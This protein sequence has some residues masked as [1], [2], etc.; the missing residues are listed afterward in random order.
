MIMKDVVGYEGLYMVREDGEIWSVKRKKFLAQRYDKS[1]YKR[2]NLHK[3][4][5]MTVLYI[6]RL[7]AEA[8]I[9]NPEEKPTVNHIDENKENNHWTNLNWMTFA[10]NNK[11]GTRSARQAATQCKSVRCVETGEVYESA[12]AAAAAMNVT[13]SSLSRAARAG[14][15]CCG[16][17]WE[18]VKENSDEETNLD[19]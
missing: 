12:K 16:Y 17:H 8:F 9:P 5:K 2:T 11:H 18:Y 10:E 7:V 3:D 6:H 19:A 15:T 1:G 14:G 13:S 4:G